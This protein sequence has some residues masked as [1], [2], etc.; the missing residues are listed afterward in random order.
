MIQETIVVNINDLSSKVAYVADVVKA[1]FTGRIFRAVNV[2]K[3]VRFVSTV[4]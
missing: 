3:M 4:L 1:Q 2:K